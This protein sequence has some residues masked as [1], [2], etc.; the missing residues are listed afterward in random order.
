M[1]QHFQGL[2]DE[3]LN[4]L[5]YS[6]W[7]FKKRFTRAPFSQH[8]RIKILD[9]LFK[10]SQVGLT[11]SHFLFLFLTFSFSLSVGSSDILYSPTYLYQSS[12]FSHHLPFSPS[13]C[14]SFFSLEPNT[15]ITRG[16]SLSTFLPL[17]LSI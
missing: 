11:H 10:A 12:T 4:I 6:A 8:L 1:N 14:E 5:V 17:S 9:N 7:T 15:M 3:I 2:L 13:L 16:L